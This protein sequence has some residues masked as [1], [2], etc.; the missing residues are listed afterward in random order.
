MKVVINQ[1]NQGVVASPPA[2]LAPTFLWQL[3]AAMQRRFPVVTKNTYAETDHP[4][5]LIEGKSSFFKTQHF[6]AKHLTPLTCILS[7]S[8]SSS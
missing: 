4:S 5:L 6:G 2:R 1:A 3:R 7:L 8:F